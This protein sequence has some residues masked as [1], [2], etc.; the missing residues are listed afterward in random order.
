MILISDSTFGHWKLEFM[1]ILVLDIWDLA[2][3][4]HSG[5]CSEFF[6]F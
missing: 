3:R 1:W 5:L 6:Q 4:L 2:E